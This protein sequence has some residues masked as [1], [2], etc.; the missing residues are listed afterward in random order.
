MTRAES[1]S[2]GWGS[3]PPSGADQAMR[4]EMLGSATGAACA[5]RRVDGCASSS[6]LSASTRVGCAS[7]GANAENA[8]SAAANTA[9]ARI[10]RIIARDENA[11]SARA[12][13]ARVLI[14]VRRACQARHPERRIRDGVCP[15]HGPKETVLASRAPRV[16]HVVSTFPAHDAR[17]LHA[18]RGYPRRRRAS[19]ARDATRDVPRGARR[20]S[21]ALVARR[22]RALRRPSRVDVRRSPCPPSARA[23]RDPPRW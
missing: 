15:S 9:R 2:S 14:T 22:R 23:R 17:A 6:H 13:A 1:S 19:R 3:T 7:A 12:I 10:K 20:T 8:R 21:R 4:K 16:R 11:R 5:S 18:L